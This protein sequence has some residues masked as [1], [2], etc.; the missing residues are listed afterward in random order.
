ML[1]LSPLPPCQSILGPSGVFRSVLLPR[2]F[3]VVHLVERARYDDAQKS[4]DSSD[5]EEEDSLPRLTSEDAWIFP[6]V[7]SLVF[8]LCVCIKK[9]PWCTIDRFSSSRWLVP[10]HQILWKGMDQL[11]TVPL[12]H[13]RWPLQRPSCKSLFL[14]LQA[15]RRS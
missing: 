2:R 12:L 6:L 9:P 5:N 15:F 8:A 4:K 7:G 13:S 11:A 1:E 10:G 3:C 14:L